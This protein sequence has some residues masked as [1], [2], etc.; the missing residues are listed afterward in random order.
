MPL[1]FELAV[2]TLLVVLNGWFA[3]SE[4]A[5]VSSRRPR[6]AGLAAGGSRGAA[7]ALTLAD[8]PMRFLSAVQIGITLVG[9]LAGAYSGA[10][11]SRSLAAAIA[12]GIPPLAAV[13]DAVAMAVVVGAITFASL[14]VGELVPKQI[15]LANPEGI[16]ARVALPMIA[17][18]RVATP[19]VWLLER[20]SRLVLKLLGIRRAKG[21]D[22]TE[23]EIRAI[24]AEG[25][26]A[27]VFRPQEEEL[28]TGV[29][30][31]GDRK[32]RAVMTPR[33]ELAWVDLAWTR[34]RIAQALRETPYSRLLVCE[35]GIDNVQG[36]V[37]A[38]DLLDASLDGKALDVAAA[39]KPV[40]VV[41]EHALALTVLDVL[42]QSEVHMALVV[43][44]YGTVE[45]L[46]TGTDLMAVILGSLSEHGDDLKGAVVQREDG[47][48]LVDGDAAVD[49][50]AGRI[51]CGVLVEDDDYDTVAGFLLTRARTIPST[52]DVFAW[53][54]WR[55]EV[56]DMDG[57]RIDKVLVSRA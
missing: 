42:R 6:L 10:N 45:G 14:I 3:M 47:S 26:Q 13:A 46:L 44:E 30:R 1:A 56:V 5:I 53:E 48:W 7:A 55:F 31:F 24:I 18:A 23:E 52:G 49:Y 54:G 40:T 19:M 16:A 36:V 33:N 29:M 51:G 39:M 8:N 2:I 32:V 28:L 38:K 12:S 43:D 21:Q 57:M 27:G 50:A 20:C 34:E 35:G 17:V 41:P 15:A 11:L 37:Q 22:V 25:T 4:L 9:V